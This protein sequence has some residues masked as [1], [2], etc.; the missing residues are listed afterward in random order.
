[1]FQLF[2]LSVTSSFL[3]FFTIQDRLSWDPQL[4]H[5]TPLPGGAH[6]PEQ[7]YT[8]RSFQVWVCLG[9]RESCCFGVRLHAV[10]SSPGLD[11]CLGVSLSH[12]VPQSLVN[13]R[14]A[15]QSDWL[16]SLRA[17]GLP[18]GLPRWFPSACC[19]PASKIMCS[20]LFPFSFF[21]KFM[22]F[23]SFTL[24]SRTMG[25][26]KVNECVQSAVL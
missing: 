9:S 26:M 12:S 20:H 13:A 10:L 25:G 21:L 22:H 3:P 8:E 14:S 1:M 16:S 11:P 24:I 5:R 19:S 4:S 6:S 18:V 17:W 15:A 7:K 2:A 23:N